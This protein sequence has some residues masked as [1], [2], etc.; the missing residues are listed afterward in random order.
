MIGL[1]EEERNKIAELLS[2]RKCCEAMEYTERI[3]ENRIGRTKGSIIQRRI[4]DEIELPSSPSILAN[5]SKCLSNSKFTIYVF[6]EVAG[7]VRGDTDILC[8]ESD[9]SMEITLHSIEEL[10]KTIAYIESL[11]TVCWIPVEERKLSYN[12]LNALKSND[13][14]FTIVRYPFNEPVHIV[15]IQAEYTGKINL[16]DKGV[17]HVYSRVPIQIQNLLALPEKK[18]RPKLIELI[19][20]L[21][22]EYRMLNPDIAL[23]LSPAR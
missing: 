18:K 4:Y 12:T 21:Y 8:D 19:K 20:N 2:R 3:A 1:V 15:N 5:A 10:E 23:I 22:K 17:I 14:W 7:A 11:D 16:G 13:C 9:N 6:G